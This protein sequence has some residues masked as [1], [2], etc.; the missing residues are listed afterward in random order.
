MTAIS[1]V[2]TLLL[3]YFVI[4]NRNHENVIIQKMSDSQFR[5]QRSPDKAESCFSF[6]VPKT[7]TCLCCA[8]RLLHTRPQNH[9]RNLFES[10]LQTLWIYR[11]ITEMPWKHDYLSVDSLVSSVVRGYFWKELLLVNE[12][13]DVL[14]TWAQVIFRIKWR[15]FVSQWCY[16]FGPLRLIAQFSRDGFGWNKRLV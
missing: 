11:H 16:K 8:S 3:I 13:Y 5:A 2:V 10:H 6:S 7:C 1:V 12:I 15:V 9:V 14:T 4:I